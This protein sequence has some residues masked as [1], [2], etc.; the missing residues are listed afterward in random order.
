M[1]PALSPHPEPFHNK[2]KQRIF[3]ACSSGWKTADEICNITGLPF[4]KVNAYLVRLRQEGKIKREYSVQ[5]YVS[6]SCASHS[7]TPSERDK[8]ISDFKREFPAKYNRIMTG[9]EFIGITITY[10]QW[11]DMLKKLRTTTPEN[12]P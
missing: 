9:A 12:N 3:D 2:N 4:Q 6:I 8:V 10:E 1:T 7:T 5:R 11:S